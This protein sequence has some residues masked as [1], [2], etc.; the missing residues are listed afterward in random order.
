M[1]T[2]VSQM[3]ISIDGYVSDEDIGAG[4]PERAIPYP[5]G[6]VI[7]GRRTYEN[8]GRWHGDHHNGVPIF[9]LTHDVP[10]DPAPG[11]VRYFTDVREWAEAVSLQRTDVVATSAATHLRFGVMGKRHDGT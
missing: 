10:P 7:S 1:R 8:A 5:D 11:S 9:V 4:E 2:V 3:G 6:A